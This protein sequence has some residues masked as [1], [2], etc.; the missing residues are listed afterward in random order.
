M[1]E[2]SMTWLYNNE[3]FDETPSK[4]FE[5]FVY[6]ITNTLNGK[7]Y[8]GKKHFW[9]RRKQKKTGRRKTLE[10]NWRN[11][12]GSCEPLSVDVKDIGKENF[13]REILYLC[14]HKKSMSYYETYEQ[15]SRNVLMTDEYYNEHIEGRFFVSERSGIYEVVLKN[16]KFREIKRQQMTGENNPS[17]RPEVRAKLSEML[18]GEGNPRYGYKNSKKHTEAIRKATMKKVT[19]GNK[20]WE[21]VQQCRDEFGWGTSAFYSRVRKGIIWYLE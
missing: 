20:V 16:D 9:T 19:D 11:Y 1:V 18:S 4:E 7:K 15:F 6:L 17:K 2:S 14:K 3:V 13:Q 21:S 10:S 5:G 12:Y 8:I